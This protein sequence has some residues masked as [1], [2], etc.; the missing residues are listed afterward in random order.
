MHVDTGTTAM[1]I[2]LTLQGDLLEAH[3]ID[4]QQTKRP[5]LREVGDIQGFSPKSRSR[6]MKFLN[7]VDYKGSAPKF[8]TLTFHGI[9]SAAEAK[10]CL[11]V[12]KERMRRAYPKGSFV[13]RYERQERGSPHFHLMMF[14]Y[15]Y[16]EQ[17]WLQSIWT[18]ITGEDLS[19]FHIK[20][21][22]GKH[23]AIYYVSKYIAKVEKVQK[24]SSFISPPY[25]HGKELWDGRQWGWH[26]LKAL[27]VH[28][29]RVIY[30][31]ETRLARIWRSLLQFHS[32]GRAGQY[33]YGGWIAPEHAEEIFLELVDMGAMTQGEWMRSM[34]A[35]WRD[36]HWT[37]PEPEPKPVSARHY[38]I[39]LNT[40]TAT[41]IKPDSP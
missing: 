40:L 13:W 26:N 18:E 5:P 4:Y 8:A 28:A 36:G 34:G 30:I 39:D 9:P 15:P 41:E 17:A 14:N 21:L 27:P 22:R 11:R 24:S 38:K 37:K 16:M 1:T 35:V 12:F 32:G 6:L 20:A 23:Q 33:G 10:R 19:I 25:L 31:T 7:T 3:E 29:K 2:R